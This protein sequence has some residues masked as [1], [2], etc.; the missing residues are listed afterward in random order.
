M[1]MN[2]W[3]RLL[4]RNA[5]DQTPFIQGGD[6]ISKRLEI[7]LKAQITSHNLSIHN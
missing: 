7:G 3:D 2:L 6:R 5:E 1:A 4:Q